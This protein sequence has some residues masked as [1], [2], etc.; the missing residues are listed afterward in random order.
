M[1]DDRRPLGHE[2]PFY[3]AEKAPCP[4]L[5]GRVERKL[6]ARLTD[7]QPSNDVINARLIASGFRRSLDILY[8]PACEACNACRPVRVNAGAFRPSRSQKRVIRRNRDI[9]ASL[10]AVGEAEGLLSL[11]HSYID[12]RH[13]QSEMANMD[14]AMFRDMIRVGP[15]TSYALLVRHRKSGVV[16]GCML[17]DD[18]GDG[19]SA[20]YSFFAPEQPERSLGHLLILSLIDIAQQKGKTWVYLGYAIDGVTNMSYKL[21]YKPY[22]II[23]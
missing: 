19:L 9:Q 15:V 21:A 12:V 10:E 18:V 11:F 20:V 3:F 14:E 4:Y 22:E 2:L 17:V 5:P 16:L 8:R 6:F 13:A 7:L 1:P 23:P